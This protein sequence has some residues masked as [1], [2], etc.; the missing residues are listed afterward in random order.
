[1]VDYFRKQLDEL[2]GANRNGDLAISAPTDYKDNRLCRDFLLGF[3]P[4]E[5]FAATK[6]AIAPCAKVHDEKIKAKFQKDRKEFGANLGSYEKDHLEICDN[7]I[8]EAEKKSVR[9][10]RKV[11]EEAQLV[12]SRAN[13]SENPEETEAK[14]LELS[15]RI[16]ECQE[17][18]EQLAEA[19]KIREAA[20][21]NDEGEKLKAR[22]NDIIQSAG[23]STVNKARLRV[24]DTCGSFLGIFDSDVRLADHFTGRLHSG[25]RELRAYVPAFRQ[26]MKDLEKFDNH[27]RS[28]DAGANKR[29]RRSHSRS[30]SRTP[31]RRR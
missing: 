30:R 25:Y 10:K 19:G 1:M 6:L 27:A 26:E 13:D 4:G 28:D 14:M 7:I 29:R 8:V 22:Q 11:E 31:P 18:A 23:S 24:C 21:V 16:A 12:A 3:C 20:A 17:K 2:M 9:A 5:K 15:A